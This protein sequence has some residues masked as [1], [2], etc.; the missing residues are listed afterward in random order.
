MKDLKILLY[1]FVMGLAFIA[2]VFAIKNT[3]KVDMFKLPK[4]GGNAD[5][6]KK[7]EDS[8]FWDFIE[9]M[10]PL[11]LGIGALL[12]VDFFRAA[13]DESFV[14]TGNE[15]VDFCLYIGFFTVSEIISFL[16]VFYI[17][18]GI[19]ALGK[20]HGDD[21]QARRN[22]AGWVTVIL[23]FIL[24]FLANRLGV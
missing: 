4:P 21:I 23:C 8:G 14:Y 16:I 22:C 10:T 11:G 15:L 5:A 13:Q 7:K 19:L 24:I 9:K 6:E 17:A 20:S 12:V 3:C 2:Y 1:L 18:Y